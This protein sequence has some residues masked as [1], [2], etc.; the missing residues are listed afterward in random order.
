[1]MRHSEENVTGICIYCS[2]PRV[3]LWKNIKKHLILPG[4]HFIAIGILGGPI[5]LANP[6]EIPV[7]FA[8]LLEQIHFA[9]KSFSRDKKDFEFL[10]VGHDCGFYANMRRQ[11]SLED[12]KF[13][14]QN[15][16]EYLE[17]RFKKPA[18]GYFYD[19]SIGD[20]PFE[21]IF[22]SSFQRL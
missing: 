7:Q 3:P 22:D 10:S 2:D 20:Q 21:G 9:L 13:D 14:V 17:D 12:K 19:E 15:G 16:C 4:Q 1:M 11:V 6:G 18:R 8:A 5:S